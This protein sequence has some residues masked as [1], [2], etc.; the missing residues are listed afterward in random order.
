MRWYYRNKESFLKKQKLR[1]NKKKEYIRKEKSKPCTDCKIKYPWYVMDFDHKDFLEKKINMYQAHSYG[2]D[3]LKKE[4][5]KCD[6][7]CSNCHRIRTFK[8]L[9]KIPL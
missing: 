4:K 2:W 5:V 6:V 8:R 9:N 7:V 3:T 1:E